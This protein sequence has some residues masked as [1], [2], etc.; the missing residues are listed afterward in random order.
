MLRISAVSLALLSAVA[1]CSRAQPLPPEPPP[2]TDGGVGD[3]P[4]GGASP[5]SAT[6]G[7]TAA[8]AGPVPDGRP[9]LP[10]W[11]WG[12]IRKDECSGGRRW[13]SAP[14]RAVPDGIPAEAACQNAPRNLLGIPFARPDRCERTG[15]EVRGRWQV[16]DSSCADA[17]AAPVRGGEGALA[18]PQPLEGYA[19]LH[20]HQMAH[21]GF[22]GSVV[23][24]GAF[25]PP[26]QV[27]TPIPAA[28][29]AGHD[30]CEAFFDGDIA[31]GL[32]GLASH[33]ES[34]Y[35][36]FSA[37]PSR[38]LAT[39]QQAYEDWLFRAY[40]GGLRLTVM[41]AVN[42]E[43]MFGRG[44][45]DLGL[46]NAITTVQPV[47]APGRT[48]NDME[49][50]EHQVRE[51][52]RMQEHLD[53]KH[54]GP[55]RGWYR[56][57]RDPEEAGA[58]IAAGRMA[59]I[60]GTEL[61]HLFNCDAD[62][63]ACSQ[64]TIT[65]GLDR[66][67]AMGVNYVFPVHHKLNQFGGPSQFN[68]LTNGPTAEC[69]ET[70]EK[71]SA[72][73]LSPLGRF[74]IEE[75]SA[76]GMLI[77]TE[78]LS[79]KAFDETLDI[80]ESR[81]Y[82]VLAGHIGPFDLKTE[83]SQTEQLR[84]TD[85]IQR[86]LGVGGMLGVILGVGVDE[87]ARSAT[88]PVPLPISCGGA[89]RWGNAY[90]YMR[91]LAGGGFLP[92]GGGRITFGSDFNGFASWPAPRYASEPC[93]PRTAGDGRPIPK[94]TPIAYPLNLPPNLVPAAVGGTSSLPRFEQFRSWDYNQLGL[95][96]AG[97]LPDFVE[98]LRS[99][100]LTL[101]DL[102]P[103]YR[104]A[105]GVVELWKTARDREVAGDRRHLRWVPSS[106]FDLM[107]LDPLAGSGRTV[108]VAPGVAICRRRRDQ[109]LGFE[110]GAACQLVEPAEPA[111]A[112]GA[113]PPVAITTYHAGRCLDVDG[114]SDR[115]GARVQQWTCNGGANQRWSLRGGGKGNVSFQL[116]NA[117]SDR[118]LDGAGMP[119]VQRSCA[120]DPAAA[121]GQFWQVVR[122]G[123]TFS[124]RSAAGL[125][126]EVSGQSRA[127]GAALALAPCT[128]AAHQQWE[129]E[130][131]RA[132]DHE[133]LYQADR[134][135]IAWL[136]APDAEHPLPVT[137]DGTRTLCR[138]LEPAPWLGLVSQG[139]CIGRTTD[140]APATT[141][142]FQQLFQAR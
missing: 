97:L 140:G 74:L 94:P 81:R 117:G 55:G 28:M 83:A 126:L 14:L 98:D 85:Q 1:A 9:D 37:W 76:R 50:L 29:K 121:P 123:N 46:V 27:L 99:M 88:A 25:G 39:H 93:Q 80:A 62:R 33:E 138:S 66:L 48:G 41:L 142:S 100:G 7:A 73:G 119:T 141:T 44:E 43:D 34:G 90:L 82:P 137:V 17:P 38:E 19:D 21:L 116:V 110:T 57:V 130:T 77:D 68:V 22:G 63:P 65:R 71:C 127:D 64:E 61:Q 103:L 101:A 92:G 107:D 5:G 79:W 13:V 75:L 131:M 69:W 8:D 124:L 45:N 104:S 128:G 18:Q 120:A 84:K 125:C 118:C 132:G 51:A 102:E 42:S 72:E 91:D 54:G 133:R 87:Y 4:A 58:V 70:Q 111:P 95:M 40:Q 86:I 35:P 136:A 26:E 56:I 112:P 122:T 6:P 113:L 134:N 32:A 47:L 67:E 30:R 139:A 115:D 129:I 11:R 23:W 96:H 105:R 3:R 20:L 53:R 52:Y 78:H 135:R 10:A 49:A 108:E 109:R 2:V 114:A 60:L 31:G 106:P 89:D 59:V 36:G 12:P 16:P 24:G 15:G